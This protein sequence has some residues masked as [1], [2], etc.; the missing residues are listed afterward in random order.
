MTTQ[1]ERIEAGPEDVRIGDTIAGDGFKWLVRNVTPTPVGVL[2]ML[3][4]IFGDKASVHVQKQHLTY[5]QRVVV[6]ARETR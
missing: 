2:M 5:D 3:S 1:A 6:V 4:P